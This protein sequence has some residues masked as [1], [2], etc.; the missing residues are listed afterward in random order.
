MSGSVDLHKGIYSLWV[1]SGLDN[2]FKQYWSADKRNEFATLLDDMA[3]AAH[4]NPY[5]VFTSEQGTT[6]TRM[7]ASSGQ[8]LGKMENRDIPVEFHIHA[9]SVKA[10]T[11]SAKMFASI[12]ADKVMAVFG[13]HPITPPQTPSLDHGNVLRVQYQSD[14]GVRDDENVWRWIVRYSFL[15]DVPVA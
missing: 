8:T 3:S 12:L 7:S 14:H 9:K 15:V 13:G 11:T 1:S 6:I 2:I 4:P 5:C 10:N